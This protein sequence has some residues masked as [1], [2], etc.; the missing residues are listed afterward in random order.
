MSNSSFSITHH[1]DSPG[2]H[3]KSISELRYSYN[4]HTLQ[5]LTLASKNYFVHIS[6]QPMEQ[7]K[8]K[9]TPNRQSM[10][11]NN[12]KVET[13]STAYVDLPCESFP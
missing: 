8:K 2:E 1:C 7:K 5:I 9:E 3:K 6:M 4:Q 11:I 13:E 10:E 12:T